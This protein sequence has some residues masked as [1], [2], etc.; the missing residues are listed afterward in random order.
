MTRADGSVLGCHG[1]RQGIQTMVPCV[2][3]TARRIEVSDSPMAGGGSRGNHPFVFP[4]LARRIVVQTAQ[5]RRACWATS[6]SERVKPGFFALVTSGES[7][8]ALSSVR[9]LERN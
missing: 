8:S 2:V 5:S 4:L 6:S 1:V 9:R 3:A 7:Q